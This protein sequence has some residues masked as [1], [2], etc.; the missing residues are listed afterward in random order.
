MAKWDEAGAGA[1]SG[2]R[3]SEV[4]AQLLSDPYTT[5]PRPKV[6][7][8]SMFK[9]FTNLLRRDSLALLHQE[10]DLV[11]PMRKLVNPAGICMFGRWKITE[12]TPYTGCFRTGVEHLI[13]VRCSNQFSNTERGTPRGF[14]FAGKIFPTLDPDEM[15]KT[16]NFICID[17]LA[18][19]HVKRYAD[20]ELTNEPPLTP[21]IS[22]LYVALVAANIVW[23]F[24]RVDSTPNYRPLYA[25]S[26]QGLA[27]GE[28]PKGPKWIGITTEE[29]IGR[30]DAADFRDELRVSN[31]KDGRLR[32]IVSAADEKSKDG[33]RLWRRIGVIELTE[34]VCSAGGDHRLRFH[35]DPNR[36]HT[37]A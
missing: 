34:D 15:V 9:G 17:D 7:I 8:G 11:P 24:N 20:V 31:Y 14:G 21:N 6:N 19:R 1:Y 26:G 35:H 5:L 28:K 2:S 12:E 10:A 16:V 29:G 27:Q 30:S 3:F 13:I 33:K 25:L 37:T 23:V 36:G 4:R 32:F 18:E 22:L